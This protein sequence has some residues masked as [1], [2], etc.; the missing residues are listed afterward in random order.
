M[1]PEELS[2]ALAKLKRELA[3][4]DARKAIEHGDDG[5]GGALFD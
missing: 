2:R 5:A 4:S 3:D 1:T